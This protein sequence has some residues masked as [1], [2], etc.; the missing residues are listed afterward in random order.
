M[1][2]TTSCEIVQ[3]D[4]GVHSVQIDAIVEI[5]AGDDSIGEVNGK[6]R[7]RRRL[8]QSMKTR[9]HAWIDAFCDCGCGYDS[10]AADGAAESDFGLGSGCDYD[11]GYDAAFSFADDPCANPM[12][13]SLYQHV[14]HWEIRNIDHAHGEEG[15]SFAVYPRRP[16]KP[17]LLSLA[18]PLQWQARLVRFRT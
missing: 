16:T 13:S 1:Y 12:L 10:H 11:C 17:V 8:H 7:W 2:A 14:V 6:N 18:S 15:S 9:R 4:H 3:S 5:C